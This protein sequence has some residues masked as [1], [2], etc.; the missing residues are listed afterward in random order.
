MVNWTTAEFI[1]F[2]KWQ[3]GIAPLWRVDDP[4]TIPIIN[5]PFQ[6]ISYELKDWPKKILFFPIRY[7]EEG[8]VKGYTSVYNISDT[9]LRIRGI[10]VLPEY[11]GQGV[12]HRMWKAA[13]GYF[14][15]S[16]Y[17]VVGFWREDS[18]PRFIEHS[19][20]SIVP[21]TEW[22]WSEYSQVNMRFLYWDRGPKPHVTGLFQ[23]RTFIR[24]YI[25]SHGYGGRNNLNT[26]WSDDEWL[27]Y[28]S[29]NA[30]RYDDAKLKYNFK[31]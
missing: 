6:I 7:W 12:G 10:Y 9:V 27:D 17:R 25:S 8:V 13:C 18:A 4:T 16:F 19:G 14:P 1:S 24:R 29:P 26:T 28:A 5:N 22:L 21:G 15:K 30:F 2:P 3:E 31:A 11:R 23:N 20:M